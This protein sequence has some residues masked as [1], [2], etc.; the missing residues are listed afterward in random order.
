MHICQSW[1]VP[2]FSPNPSPKSS[3]SCHQSCTYILV[4][5]I[6]KW[7]SLWVLHSL[8]P[9]GNMEMGLITFR[10]DWKNTRFY[11]HGRHKSAFAL[12]FSAGIWRKWMTERS[13]KLSNRPKAGKMIK[14][15]KKGPHNENLFIKKVKIL[16]LAKKGNKIFWFSE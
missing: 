8:Y 6:Y 15:G 16:Q 9:D 11:Q 7:Y 1:F 4:A 3:K 14:V 12:K 13:G 2:L 5:K 10:P